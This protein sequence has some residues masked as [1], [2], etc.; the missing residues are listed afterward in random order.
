MHGTGEQQQNAQQQQQRYRYAV[1]T[2]EKNQPTTS[3]HQLTRPVH[4]VHPIQAS[5]MCTPTTTTAP[6]AS[7]SSSGGGGQRFPSAIKRL[8]E[9]LKLGDSI[10]EPAG[11]LV[12]QQTDSLSRS[13]GM[14]ITT[15]GN[16]NAVVANLFPIGATPVLTMQP[17]LQMQNGNWYMTQH[18]ATCTNNV[19]NVVPMSSNQAAPSSATPDSGIQSVPTSPPSPSFG[20]LNG[21]DSDALDHGEEEEEEEVE[22]SPNDDDDDPADFTDMPRLK[23]IDEDDDFDDE[24]STSS[25]PFS[26]ELNQLSTSTTNP[27]HSSTTAGTNHTIPCEVLPNGMNAEEFWTVSIARNMDPDEIVRRLIAFDPDK[28]NSIAMLIKKRTAEES[29]KKKDMEAE[30]SSTTPTTPRA[31]G[32]RKRNKCDERSTNSPDVTTSN[33]PVE[34]STSSMG[35]A[36]E[37]GETEKADGKRRGRKPKRRKVFHKEVSE[38]QGTRVGNKKT[39]CEEQSETTSI[40]ETAGSSQPESAAAQTVDPVQFRL[41]VHEMMQRQLEQLTEKMSNDMFEL[42]LS[43]STT[44]K[45]ISGKRKESFLRQLNEQSKKLKK[46]GAPTFKRMRLFITESQNDL[47]VK[48]FDAQKEVKDEVSSFKM[49]SKLHSRRSRTAESPD[50]CLAPVEEKFNGEYYEIVK[51]VPFSDDIIALWKAPSL[52]CGCTKGACTSDI[53][54]LN[55]ALRVQCNNECT[56]SYCSNRRFWKDDCSHK[57]CVSNGPK[58]KRVLKTKVARRAGEFLCEY[59]GEVIT[60]EKARQVFTENEDSRVIAIGSQLFIDATNRGNIARFIK[61]SCKPNSRFEVWSVGGF[62]RA[63]IFALADLN[64]NAE[65]TV[66]KNG[67]LPFATS[68]NCE[69]VGC[70]K[71]IS[72]VRRGEIVIGNEKATIET[73]RFLQRNRRKTIEISRQSGLP[74]ILQLPEADSSL[75]SKMK[76]TLAAFTFRVR[77][78]DGSMARSMLPYYS[79]IRTYLKVRS[80]NPSV[81]EFVALFRKWID[82]IDDDDLERAFVAIEAHYLSS[83]LLSV[84]HPSKKPHD[85]SPR[86]QTSSSSSISPLPSKREADLSYLE[87]LYPIGSYDPDDAWE[88]YRANA[89]DNAVRCLCGAL[90]EDGGMVQCDKCHFWLHIDCCEYPVDE[91]NKKNENTKTKKEEKKDSDSEENEYICDFCLGTQTSQ[92][93]VADV[94]LPDQ[95]EVRFESCD[96]YRSLMNRR[97]IQVRLNETVYVNR[98]FPEDH[99]IMLRN[100]REEKKGSKHKEPNKYHFPKADSD[101]L[102]SQNVERKDARI[103]RVERLFICP[104]NNRF[105]FGSFYAW[106]HETFADTG[107]VFCRKEVFA[108]PYYETLPLDEVIGRCLVIDTSTWTRGR[109]KVP[110]FKEEDIFLCEMQ[111]G[112]NQRQFEKVPPKNRYPINTQPYVFTK[113]SQPK[114]VIKDFRPYDPSNP[115]PKP[116]KTLTSS[117]SI[118]TSSLNSN[119]QLSDPLPDVDMK[120]LSRKNIQRVLKRL[121]KSNSKTS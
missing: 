105:V 10:L 32:S 11:T 89:S 53:E 76:K 33:L 114:K 117:N 22:A 41:K 16:K 57:L 95:P 62:Y 4:H 72:G 78:I 64:A 113:F 17:Q 109:P 81:T 51:S 8:V 55:R 119:P 28:A 121:I 59:A 36:D 92:R 98:V 5:L 93:P 19:V 70:N 88:T 39:E 21:R 94:R 79:S 74:S 25:G 100:L 38:E 75:L 68:C 43:H 29:K 71:V 69:T 60:Y 58:T 118:A 108:T 15:H 9:P 80:N 46:S 104:G 7:I 63:G 35:M 34:P 45:T 96:Y 85:N 65:I 54:C 27:V 90:D 66:D 91:D 77:R 82:V 14:R 48:P 61:H 3:S 12:F 23:P 2:E 87:S 1:R 106:P 6:S 73:R 47:D 18:S 49:R 99:K 31:R 20:V 26:T 97:G 86:A 102:P 111:I 30:V 52:A 101:P 24:P 110:K 83:S 42:R 13:S 103:F 107:R 115:S 84:E 116:P 120:K 56:L 112:K 67:L 50:Y 37:T 40:I 44:T